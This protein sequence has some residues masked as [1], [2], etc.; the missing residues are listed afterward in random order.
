MIAGFCGLVNVKFSSS[1]FYAILPTMPAAIEKLWEIK[2]QLPPEANEQL[3]QYHPLLRQILYHRGYITARSAQEYLEARAPDDN[4]PENLLG[5]QEAKERIWRAIQKQERIAVY[6]DYD[7]DGVTA[8]ALLTDLLRRLGADVRGYI[9]NRFDEGY[10]LN[11]EALDNL[12][13]DGVR[14]VV[15]VDCG[16]RSLEEA[17]HAKKIGLDLII[18]DHHQPKPQLPEAIALVNPKQPGDSYP[19][20]NLAGVGLAYKLAEALLNKA[21]Q[22]GSSAATLLNAQE[23]CDLVA[24]GTVSDIA[25]LICENRTFV[26]QGLQLIRRPSRQGV[27]SLIGAAQ[28]NASQITAEHISFAL[29]P[30]LNAAGRLDTA[31]DALNLLLTQEVSEAARLAQRLDNQNRERQRITRHI[32][33]KAE[34]QA[35][36]RDPQ[37]LLLF[38]ADEEFNPG[39]IGLAAARLCEQYYRP[40]IVA[41]L[42]EEFTRGSC[43]SIP[44]FHI[45]QALDECADLLVRHGG[46]AAAAGFTVHN[47]DLPELI[48]RLQQ[49]AQS[50][51]SS[52]DLRPVLSID[53]KVELSELTPELLI[54]LEQL[55]PTGYGNPP[56]RFVSTGV[57]VISSRAVGADA[58]HLKLVVKDGR[59]TYDAI[60]FRQGHLQPNLPLHIDLVF[61]FERNEYNGRETLQL[62]VI[63]LRPSRGS[64]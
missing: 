41:H 23:Y 5:I 14:L 45:T 50:K 13:N 21:S 20:K 58:S 35:F 59:I 48:E 39:V 9:P 10:G 7:A 49:I 33:Q 8:T 51:L 42:G 44:E 11:I 56:A 57:R 18:T 12:R 53:A 25:P 34:A 15:T 37:A 6:G 61:Q 4:A 1:R 43:R 52:L 60:A 54:I 40:T 26:R 55:Q 62:N 63:D 24:L 38:S 64:G 29:G 2:P 16:A 30:R 36:S 27:M 47:R 28:L 31:L 46:H 17:W 22:E 32:Q 3:R 19:D